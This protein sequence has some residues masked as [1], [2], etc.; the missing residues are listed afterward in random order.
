MIGPG[1]REV[2]L[3]ATIAFVAGCA[4]L[5]GSNSGGL[6]LSPQAATAGRQVVAGRL[7]GP[8]PV[9]TSKFGGPIFGWAIDENGTDGVL[10]EVT[11]LTFPSKSV[12]ETFDQ[13][14]AR[15]VKVVRK[16]STG[17]QGN[18]ELSVYGIAAN[19]VGL[20][21]DGRVNLRNFHRHDVYYVM[22]PVT[23]N[24]ISGTW[25]RPPGKD[26]RIVNVPDQQVDPRF[27]MAATV[28]PDI[29]KPPHFEVVVTD[30]ASNKILRVLHPPRLDG[31]NFPYFVAEDTTTHHAYVPAANYHSQTVFI[32]FDVL[33][34]RVSNNF[35][36]PPFSGPVKGI[37]I[38]SATHMMCTTTQS[39]Y[40]VQMYDLTTKKQTFVG[41]IPNS[42]G[43]LQAPSSIAADPV[44]HLFLVEQPQSL[45]GGS[46][47]YVYDEEGDI[48]ETLTGF[49]FPSYTLLPASPIHIVPSSRSGYVVGPGANQ[50]QSFTY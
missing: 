15:I 37:A 28:V 14:I 16:Q 17:K 30:I 29:T 40:S 12:V 23:G 18:R 20:I 45:R 32:D 43:E 41:Q 21:D 13:T 42:G 34:G 31:V 36:A 3:L 11:S 5:A 4:K 27:V 38:D 46:D 33:T 7:V 8:G 19:D 49:Q 9:L 47:I 50:L 1:A 35:V 25:T 24:K 39:N 44:N 10:T 26:F 6:P 22:A 2:A 48:V